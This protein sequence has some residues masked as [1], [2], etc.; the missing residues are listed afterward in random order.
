MTGIPTRFTFRMCFI[1]YV[2][3]D[4]ILEMENPVRLDEKQLEAGLYEEQL[5]D[6]NFREGLKEYEIICI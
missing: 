1:P 6:G 4:R 5:K 3:C 2:I